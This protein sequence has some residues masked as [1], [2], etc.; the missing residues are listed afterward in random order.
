MPFLL[1]K[2]PYHHLRQCCVSWIIES[3][4]SSVYLPLPPNTKLSNIDPETDLKQQT[5][6]IPVGTYHG[7]V[8]S[9]VIPPTKHPVY[10]LRI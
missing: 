3:N 2:A 9:F 10:K 6:L 5:P 7:N 4:L 8:S 1:K